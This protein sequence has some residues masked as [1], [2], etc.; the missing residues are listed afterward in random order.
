MTPVNL[1]CCLSL[2]L[3]TWCIIFEEEME[4]IDLPIMATI[5]FEM[6]RQTLE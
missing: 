1:I 3:N 6:G 4:D 2:K 5:R